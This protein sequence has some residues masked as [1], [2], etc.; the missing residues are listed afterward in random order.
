MRSFFRS[1][2]LLSLTLCASSALFVA[3]RLPEATAADSKG[4]AAI[5]IEEAK[6]D[7]DFAIQGEYE[8]ELGDADGKE[9]WGL[10]VIALG[11]GK[12]KAVAYSG[13]LPGAGWDKEKKVEVD[14]SATNGVATFNGEK[15]LATIK[16]GV[17]TIK[18]PDGKP[19]GE[20]KKVERKSPTIGKKSPEGAVVLFDGKNGDAFTDPKKF[21][22]GLMSQGITSTQKF[23]DFSLHMEF[24][25]SYVPAGR[26][27]GRANS[28]CYMQGRYEVQILDSFGLSGENNECGG[29]YT[30][31][32]PAVNMCLPPLAWQTYDAD[33]TAA[34]FD[35]DKKKTANAKLTVRHNGVLI[36]ENVE[37]PKGTTAAP[38]AEG[39]EPGPIYIQDHGNPIRF[40]NIWLVEKKSR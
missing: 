14:G 12:F 22:D 15:G 30:I 37:L 31:A 10:Q 4:I 2:V 39:P 19:L 35:G 20:M 26:G 38:V 36:H 28:G 3:N 9:K 7:P 24:L 40:R 25:L 34:K 11:D 13:G 18:N 32:K 29:I 1:A 17:A 5:T 8:G 27:Q 6:K 21:V 33:Y 23:Q 16:D